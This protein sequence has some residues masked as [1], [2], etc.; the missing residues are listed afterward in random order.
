MVVFVAKAYLPL[1]RF[2][3]AFDWSLVSKKSDGTVHYELLSRAKLYICL[4]FL[5]F[6]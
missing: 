6:I 4:P 1:L 3:E 5:N 2:T